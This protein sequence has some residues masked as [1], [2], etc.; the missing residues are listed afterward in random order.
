MRIG[1]AA[2][3]FTWELE[4]QDCKR[5]GELLWTKLHEK[6]PFFEYHNKHEEVFYTLDSHTFC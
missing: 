2:V 5:S 6:N 3:K 4:L 1:K